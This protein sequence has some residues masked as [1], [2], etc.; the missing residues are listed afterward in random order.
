[1]E[2]VHVLVFNKYL[3]ALT[4]ALGDSGLIHLTN[5]AN[6]SKQQLLQQLDTDQDVRSIEQMLSRCQVLLE[7]LGVDDSG[8]PPQMSQLTQDEISELF[9]KIDR[10]YKD[11]SEE[12]T[13]LIEQHAN[14]ERSSKSLAAFPFQSLRLDSLRNLSQ[15]HIEAGE[16]DEESFVRA[17]QTLADDAIFIPSNEKATHTLVVTTRKK[18]YAVNDAL[19][20]FGFKRFELPEI[21]AS[22]VASEREQLEARLSELRRQINDARLSIVAL[23]ENY[24][25]PLLAI[26]KQLHGLLA[27]RQAQGLFGQSRQ[28]YCISGWVP[29]SDMGKLQE[30]VDKTTDG[31]GIIER[32]P[33]A[34]ITDEELA[35]QSVPVQ[36]SE[37]NLTKP[38]RMLVTNFGVPNYHE[39]DPSFFVGI[40]F[41]VMFGYMFGDLGQG[42]VLAGLGVWMHF[43]RSFSKTTHD[44]G[45]LLLWCGISAMVFGV[46][47]GSVFGNEELL[48]HLWISPSPLH[49]DIPTLLI[50]SVGI[51]VVFLSV[52]LIINIFN[53]F[54]ARKFFEGT[55]DKYGILG[56]LFYWMCLIVALKVAI[57][58]TIGTVTLAILLTPL[59][60]I[61]LA[62]PVHNLIKHRSVGGKEGATAVIIGSCVEILETLT[63]YL[64]GT[65][66]FVRVGA[67]AISHAALC[68]AIYTIMQMF[69]NSVGGTA[70]SWAI[71][72]VGNIIIIAFEGMVAAIQ[73]IRL[74]YYEMFSRFF[75]GGGVPYK[76]FKLK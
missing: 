5:A 30:V 65:L 2:K 51:G 62:H 13:R 55:F 17:R 22:S 31:T 12:I 32:I 74:E 28:L 4:V 48:H 41:L 15:L 21:S 50:T 29:E 68:L 53:R 39:L 64:S 8:T 59:V 56:L 34:E 70:A 33:A 24:G 44:F 3:G 14:T 45:A 23:G 46:L 35:A 49:S 71:N 60:L 20:K 57:T 43:K 7:A 75:Q 73:C 58:G 38:F 42:A 18:H 11:S 27:I 52:A 19:S 67:Y 37:N 9:E 1:M 40:T 25:G 10:L 72:I 76:P 63:G 61:F 54:R 26:R 66:S 16:L 47:Y 69:D 36:L 6:E